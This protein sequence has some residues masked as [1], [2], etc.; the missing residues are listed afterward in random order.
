MFITYRRAG[1]V[2]ALLTFAAV[3]LAATVLAVAVAAVVL[4]VAA[5]ALVWRAVR[6]TSS[7]HHSVSPA[8]PWPQETIETTVV[9]PTGSSGDGDLLRIDTGKSI[10]AGSP[11]EHLARERDGGTRTSPDSSP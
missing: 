10:A 3:A 2:F 8:T 1:G 9:N 11:H 5:A 6:P 7:G 4:I